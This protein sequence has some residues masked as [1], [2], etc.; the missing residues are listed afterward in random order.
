MT[1]HVRFTLLAVLTA[2]TAAVAA[3][4]Q[5]KPSVPLQLN[6]PITTNS[7]PSDQ[8]KVSTDARRLELADAYAKL[9]LSFEFNHGQTDGSIRF[10][11]HGP[12]YSLFLTPTEAVLALRG[13][14]KP[15]EVRPQAT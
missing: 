13:L 2:M 10:L 15:G 9:P 4:Q 5:I 6:S 12:G 8:T 3:Q 1:R 14:A 7:V 11:S